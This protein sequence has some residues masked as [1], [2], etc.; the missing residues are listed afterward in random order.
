M[1][2]NLFKIDFYTNICYRKQLNINYKNN[3]IN[4]KL[5]N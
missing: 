1:I 2:N 4:K 3:L 5:N